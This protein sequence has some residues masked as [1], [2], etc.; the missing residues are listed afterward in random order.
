MLRQRWEAREQ[1]GQVPSIEGLSNGDGSQTKKR[2]LA[3]GGS[4]VE[5][6]MDGDQSQ[7]LN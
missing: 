1:S 4:E 7:Q 3:Q 5:L 6:D 2:R